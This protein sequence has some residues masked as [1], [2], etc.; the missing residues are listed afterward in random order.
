MWLNEVM[1]VLFTVSAATGCRKEEQSELLPASRTVI[2]YLAA[3]N[4]LSGDAPV[5]LEEMQ[6]GYTETG[7]N[8][9]VLAD[10]ADEAPYLLRITKAGMQKLKSYPEFNSAD[11]DRLQN[12]L[13]EIVAMYPAENYGL[14]LWS[15]GTSWL[16]DGTANGEVLTPIQRQK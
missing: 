8:L 4:D 2:V 9:I 3:D 16:P 11:A 5:D 13:D 14:V 12:V 10:M 7:T 1:I 6:R 15:H